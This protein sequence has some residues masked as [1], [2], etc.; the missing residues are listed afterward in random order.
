L[1]F[2]RPI[3]ALDFHSLFGVCFKNISPSDPDLSGSA[4]ASAWQTF[5]G[6]GSSLNIYCG[7]LSR[8]VTE[9]DLRQAFEAYG[10][11]A[12][13]NLVKEKFSGDSRGFGFVEMP[14]GAQAQAAM[15]AL[16]GT[17]IKGRTLNAVESKPR[18]EKRRSSGGG[19]RYGGGGG[20]RRW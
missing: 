15:A 13:V 1:T 18:T 12:L 20:G 16:N 2:P 4:V 6:K 9:E 3:A 10:T 11:V 19:H 17:Q 5:L 14:D 8:D 7:N